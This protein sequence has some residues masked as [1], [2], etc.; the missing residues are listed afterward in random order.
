M[1]IINM[2]TI[3][4]CIILIMKVLHPNIDMSIN[5]S[6]SL[7]LEF[8]LL[9]VYP[10]DMP[11]VCLRVVTVILDSLL[12]PLVYHILKTSKANSVSAILPA[13]LIATGKIT[14]LGAW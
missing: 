2:C 4:I 13:L 6:T 1:Y 12:T 9:T 5:C 3:N 8:H 10:A 14:C 11:Y 7:T